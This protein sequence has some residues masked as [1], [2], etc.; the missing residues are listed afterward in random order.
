MNLFGR[1]LILVFFPLL[2]AYSGCGSVP[3]TTPPEPQSDK[4]YE[5]S[6][7]EE[8]APVE[9]D[10]IPLTRFLRDAGDEQ[11]SVLKIYVALLD[12]FG[13]Q[14]KTPAVFRFELYQAVPRSA[15]PRGKRIMLWPDIDLTKADKNNKYWRDFLRAYEFN[16]PFDPG[17]GQGYILQAT[18][19][20]PDGKRLSDD[21][22]LLYEH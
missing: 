20:C 10:I 16:L 7:Y 8:F 21:F 13:S 3:E 12:A 9:A 2:L 1:T 17:S 6:P 14:K 22:H 4:Y 5:S 19:L 11:T 15:M 18:C